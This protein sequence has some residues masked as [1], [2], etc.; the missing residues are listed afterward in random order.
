MYF[1]TSNLMNNFRVL[2]DKKQPHNSYLWLLFL[3]GF[4]LINNSIYAQTCS[5]LSGVI[6]TYAPVTNISGNVVTIGTKSGASASFAVGDNVVLIQM[7]GPPPVQT[8]SNMGKYELKLVTAVSGNSI[9]LNSIS[10]TYS[11]STEKVQL[12]RAPSCTTGT[13]SA[14]VTAKIWDGSTGG[15]IALKGGTLTLNANIDATGTGFSQTNPPTTTT[16]TSLSS[17]VGSTDGRGFSSTPASGA[18][19]GG[20]GIGGGG[21]AGG[22]P[23]GT[24][25]LAGYVGGGAGAIAIRQGI[26]GGGGGGIIGGGGGGGGANGNG[27]ANGAGSAGGGGGVGGGGGGG[28]AFGGGGGGVKGVSNGVSYYYPDGGGGSGGGSYG[29]GGGGASA[30]LGGDDSYA[31]GGGGSW[32]GGGCAGVSGSIYTKIG[33]AGN[34]PVSVVIDDNSH[35]LN[36]AQPRLMMG[37]AGGDAFCQTGGLG[38]GIIIMEVST[39]I[40]NSRLIQSNGEGKGLAP[41]CPGLTTTNAMDYGAGGGGG[42]G[43]GQM[44]LRVG[45]FTSTAISI[46]GGKGGDGN[47][48][49][50][51][52]GGVAG[53]GG[54]GGGVW[55]YSTATQTNTGGNS[56]TITGINSIGATGGTNGIRTN[57]PKNSIQTGTGGCGGKGLIIASNDVPAWPN[58]TC[59]ISLTATPSTCTPATNTHNLTGSLTFTNA[60]TSGTLTVSM[61]G[62]TQVFNAPFTSPQAYTLSGL[63]ADGASHTVSAVFSADAACTNSATYTAPV[64]CGCVVAPTAI[65][66]GETYIITANSSLTSFKW[67][68]DGVVIAGANVNTYEVTT[69]GSYTYSAIGLDGCKD[70]LCCSTVFTS[71]LRGTLGNYFWKDTNNNGI[72]DEPATAAVKGIIL[73]LWR[74]GINTNRKDTTDISGLYLFTELDSASYQVKIIGGIADTCQISPKKNVLA[75]TEVNDSDFDTITGFSDAVIIDPTNP[76]SPAL[77]D[78]LDIDGALIR[79]CTKPNAGTDQ[80]LACANAT[81]NTLTTSTTLVPVTAG[82]TFTQIGTTPALAT[83]AGNAVSAMT[84]AGTY[85]FQYS[86]TG[87]LDTV[88]VSVQPCTGCVKPNAGTD[89][90]AVCQPV[91]TAKLTAVTT[92]GTWGAQTGNPATATIDNNGNITGLSTAGT[93]KFIYSVTGGGITCTDTAQVVVNAKPTITDGTATICAGVSV[94]LTTKITSY[95]T[96]LSPVWTVATAGGTAVTTPTAVKPTAT[97]TYVLVAQNALGCKD[98]ANVVVTVNAKPNAG[99]DQTLA[100]ANAATNTLTTSTT[101]VPVTTGGTFTQIGT[102]PALTTIAGNAVSAMTVAG[103]YQFQYSVAG[104]LDTVAVSV[105]PCTGCVKP[106]A[107]TDAAAVCQPV[108]TAKLTAVTTGGTWGAQTGNPATATIDNNGNITGLSTAGT[109]KFI[110]SVTG[111]GITCTD[112]AQVVVN[113][114]P[115]ITDGTATICAGVSVDLTTKITSYATYLSPVWTVA[116]AGGTAVTTPTAV[117]PTATTTYVLVAQNAL[118]C[119]DT[120]NVVVTVNAK[121][122]AGTDQT[123][124]C[125]NAATNTLTTSTT[126]VP[127]TT[128]GTFTQI[129]T[130]PALTTIA[131]NAVSAMTVAGTYQ[132][133]YSVAGCLDTVAVSVQPCTG[134]VKPNAGADAAAVCQPVATAKLTAVTTGG[135]WGAQTGNPATATIDN[136]GNIAGL[137]TA[138]TYK[139]IYSVTGGGITCTDTAQVMVNAKPTIA[140]GTATICA[141]VS[142]DLTSKITSY[143]TYLSPVWTIATAGGTAVATPTAVQPTAT[144]TYVL[145]AQNALGCKDTANVVVTVNAKP[146][147]GTDQTLACANATTN[148]LTT[149]T[150]LVPVTAGGTFTQ[151]GTTPALATIAGNAVS[152]MTVAGTYQFQYSVTGCLDTVAVS[153]QPCT[154][155]VKPNAGVDQTLICSVAGIAPSSAT[156]VPV[157]SGGIWTAQTGNPATT[158]INANAV[159]GMTVSG[160]YK[161]IYSVTSGGQICTDTVQV[162]VPT[163]IIP[164][165]SLGDFV[166]KDTNNNGIQDETTANAGG[167]VNVIVE[168]YKNGTLFNKDTTDA[169]GKYLFSNLDAGTYKIKIVSTTLPV[170][171]EIS[172]NPNAGTDDAKDSDVDK[173]TGFSGDYLIDPTDPTKKDILTVDAGVSIPCIKPVLTAGTVTC[174]GTTYSVVFYSNSS[175]ITVSSGTISGNTITAIP[176]GTNVTITATESATCTISSTILSPLACPSTCILPNLT[177]GQPVCNGATYSVSFTTDKGTVTTNAGTISGNSIINIPFGTDAVVTATD[178]TCISKVSTKSPTD[179]SIVTPPPYISWSGPICSVDGKT[180]TINYILSPGA[181]VT[182]SA[183]TIGTNSITGIPIG[184]IATLTVRVTGY[185]PIIVNIPSPTNCIVPKGSLGD[186]VWKDANN[187]GIQDE[188][189]ANAG[190]VANVIVELYKNGTLLTKDT[191]DA[192]GKYLFSNLDAGTYKIKIVNTTLPVGCEISSNPNAGTDDAK[193]SDVDKTTGFSGD[194]VINPTDPTKKDILTVD[195]G[196]TYSCTKPILSLGSAICNGNGTYSVSL[197]VSGG[198]VTTSSGTVSGNNITGIPVGTNVIVTASAGLTCTTVM[199]AE[200]PVSCPPINN[201]TLPN[202]SVGTAVCTGTTYAVAFSVSGGT[203]TA[204]AGTVG[205]G[206]I[207]GIPAGTDLVITASNSATCL[208][209]IVV[210]AP[211][212]CDKP[213]VNPDIS[214]GMPVCEGNGATTFSVNYASSVGAVVTANAGTVTAN[215][216]TGVPTGT[217]LVITVKKAGCPDKMVTVN[218]SL[219]NCPVLKGSLGDF[220]WKDTNNNGIQDETTA[221]A[222]GVANVIVELYKNGTLFNKDTTD[223]TG[224]YLFTNLDAGTYKIKIVSTTLPAGCEISSNPNAGTDDTKDSDVDKTTGFSGDYVINPIDPTKKDI[225]TVDAALITPCIQPILTVGTVV[226]SGTTYSVVFNSN[227]TNVTVNAG[228][229]TGNIVIGIPI[230]TNVTITAT[231]GTT[232][233]N[234]IT[235]TAPNTCPS[236]CILPNLTLGQPLCNGTTY[237]VSFTTDKGTVTTNVGTISGNSIINIPVGTDVTVTATDGTCISKISTKSPTD[238]SNVNPPPTISLSGPLCSVDGK[239]YTMSFITTPGITVTASA[240]TVGINTITGIPAGVALTITMN[241]AGYPNK[242]IVIQAPTNCVVCTKSPQTIFSTCVDNI[243]LPAPKAGQVWSIVGGNPSNATINQSGMVSGMTALGV[244]HFTLSNT[245]GTCSETFDVTHQ[246]CTKKYDLS[247]KKRVNKKLPQLNEVINYTIVVKNEGEGTATGVEVSDTLP[248]GLQYQ[249]FNVVRGTGVYNPNTNVWNLGTL[250]PGDSAILTISVK[251][252]AQGVMFNK[253]EISKMNEKDIDSTPGNNNENEDDLG[254]AC[255]S[256]PITICQGEQIQVTIPSTFQNVQWFKTVGTTT[257]FVQSGNTIN[258]SASGTYTYLASNGNCPAAGCCPVVVI[259]GDCCKPNVCIP[260]GIIKTRGKK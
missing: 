163:C 165:G 259:V 130:T 168:L 187:N 85:Q 150:T 55:L 47:N 243:Q 238:C 221:N 164:K 214:V 32:T 196:L 67:Y 217:A 218:G 54:G 134:C 28:G 140:D 152:A 80:T 63:T 216:I 166:W 185:N 149:S 99:T 9:T 254:R 236:T 213:C 35:Y 249:S 239:T 57:N 190:G 29:G 174:L 49:G 256:V 18:A 129:G 112:T 123:L 179:C 43:G 247:L 195:A 235:V 224:H 248:S 148:T 51:Y 98:T 227:S 241:A 242:L 106:N 258:F 219:V 143:A 120:A 186:F 198:T 153:V 74:N 147:A 240:G 33:G 144:T 7:T 158:T 199:T 204:S 115:T 250:V 228:T 159:S 61:G 91:A 103:T 58:L 205:N 3:V 127:V 117:K 133:Q 72:Q 94:D 176:L 5:S 225:L 180:Y 136:N 87:C 125:A 128:G 252:V 245:N 16:P 1:K 23:S 41:Y 138:G 230:A 83:I 191:T 66:S 36:A 79:K 121:P 26:N 30:W 141:G 93:Y 202:L 2:M 34:N 89:A 210:K 211:T 40:G 76:V 15:V 4:L 237:S 78:N 200:S 109:Y 64:S 155:C 137:S 229:I 110:Y 131:G 171:C 194:Y 203:V 71:C 90:A 222:G 13:V 92:G 37:G 234:M 253:A 38:G 60:P 82:G 201:C 167:V 21:G 181:T 81:T 96:Y 220:V 157:T 135:T 173:T 212:D 107:G 100:C 31:G 244:Y 114:K 111:G 233:T 118:G 175:N 69:P 170:G 142:V 11:F 188:T 184:V 27:V 56:V 197:N 145:V 22:V 172:S 161:F 17:G 97:T 113:A 156:L 192:T 207:T 84:V 68:K 44:S 132:F 255:I 39:V 42:G 86:V 223:A 116:T 10:N 189:T 25:A 77:K 162:L 108:A 101:L 209:K 48:N 246:D 206:V 160:V 50:V 124:A 182:S 257:V 24:P 95:A 177:L 12:V 178:G 251:V 20:G 59:S 260:Y 6:N 53:A 105:Q 104:C 226:C 146:N 102:T 46:A 70:S 62:V 151:I 14:A 215:A 126:L 65:C 45:V 88:A 183:G 73:E 193:D 122:N 232:C 52:H 139:F 8:G 169:T 75:G 154:G 19:A 208:V 231:E 119:K